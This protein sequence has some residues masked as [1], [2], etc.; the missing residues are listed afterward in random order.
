MDKRRFDMGLARRR[1]TLGDEYVD[2]ALAGADDFTRPFQEALTEFCWGFCWGD[3]ALDA[4]TRSLMNLTMIA[5]LG[6]MEEWTLH[7][8]GALR[9]GVSE[10]E[11]RAA[12]HIVGVYCGAPAALQCF[13][14]AAPILRE[15]KKD[16]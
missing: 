1:A 9:N 7:C 11:L 10:A 16:G 6:R 5:A 3:D 4:K 15:H 12:I 14:A 2:R 13:H 8:R